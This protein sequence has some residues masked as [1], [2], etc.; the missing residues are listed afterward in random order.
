MHR[1]IL[2]ALLPILATGC[3]T[4][5]RAP[6]AVGRV[7]DAQTGYPLHGVSV[8][9]MATSEPPFFRKVAAAAVTTDKSGKFNLSPDS[10]TRLRFMYLRNPDFLR[11]SFSV[12]AEGY[13]TNEVSGTANAR[14]FWRVELG[15]IEIRKL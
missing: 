7:V 3:Y 4:E 6:G 11:G 10:Q 2:L 15:T 14:T 5:Y 8:M 9:R 1:L 12:L 13:R